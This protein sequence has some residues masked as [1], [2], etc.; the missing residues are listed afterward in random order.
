[1]QD[2]PKRTIVMLGPQRREPTVRAALESLLATSKNGEHGVIAGITAGWEEREA[3]DLEL[4]A[5]VERPVENLE[6]HRRALAV[7]DQDPDL[8]AALQQ[9]HDVLTELQQLYRLQLRHLVPAV[10]ELLRREGRP[11]LIG[12]EREA[13]FAGLRALDEHHVERVREIHDQSEIDLQLDTRESL[14]RHRDEVRAILERAAALCI[15]GGHVGILYN[16][17]WLFGVARSLPN[18][19]PIVAWSA[20]AM[21]I[22]TRIVL[23]HDSPPQGR[24]QAEVLGPGLGLVPGVVP[25]PHARRRLHLEDA[26]RVQL[27]SRRFPDDFCA[28][29]DPGSELTWD[30]EVLTA[31]DEARRLCPSGILTADGQTTY[32]PEGQGR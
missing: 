27:L 8:L 30:G 26:V 12:P 31:S 10:E 29:L 16:R 32:D 20:G 14:K 7:F 25:L 3:E 24:G 4:G 11:E 6:L 1:M 9:R 22:A 23:F 13:A 21:T 2:T 15:A 17:L 5:H 19:L 28:A 18:T